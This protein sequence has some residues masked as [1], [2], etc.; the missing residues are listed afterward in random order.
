V[1]IGLERN[2]RSPRLRSESRTQTWRAGAT[3]DDT[4]EY[5]TP[6]GS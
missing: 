5:M 2:V 4:P 6:S 3:A 1:K